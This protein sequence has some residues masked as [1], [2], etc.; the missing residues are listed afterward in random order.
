[1]KTEVYS[2]CECSEGDGRYKFVVRGKLNG[3]Y[4]RKYFATKRDAST[5]AEIKNIEALNQGIEHA[6][7][8]SDLRMQ[9]QAA[10]ELLKPHGATLLE[11]V[12]IALP[13]LQAR[14]KSIPV[15]AAV[16][17]F[18]E[19]YRLNGGPKTTVPSA[20]YLDYL[21]DMLGPFKRL[22]G[23]RLVANVDAAEIE[24]LLHLSLIHI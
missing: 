21:S 5:W 20:S 22:Y 16:E 3:K 7:F 1:M 19:D 24:A 13:I 11:A 10:A 2:V 9:A 8:S 12:K 14:G 23:D 17:L 15:N 6:G 4:T 18:L